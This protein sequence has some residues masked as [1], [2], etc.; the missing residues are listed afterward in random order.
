L[1][2]EP[3]G[4]T[5]RYRVTNMHGVGEAV[6]P[7]AVGEWLDGEGAGTLTVTPVGI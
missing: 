5:Y 4:Q 1:L 2:R 3:G 7:G 6:H